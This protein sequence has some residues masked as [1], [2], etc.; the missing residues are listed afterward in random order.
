MC[1][2]IM[3][4]LKKYLNLL[5]SRFINVNKWTNIKTERD[6]EVKFG[7]LSSVNNQGGKSNS[8]VLH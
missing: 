7:V 6:I 2:Y 1:K 8:V 3:V 5:G 4:F